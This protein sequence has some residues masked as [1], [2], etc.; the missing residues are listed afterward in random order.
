MASRQ[1]LGS[2]RGRMYGYGGGP[3]ASAYGGPANY[4]NPKMEQWRRQQSGEELVRADDRAKS[5]IARAQQSGVG[6]G[7]QEQIIRHTTPGG[8]GYNRQE[9]MARE[10][11]LASRPEAEQI[12]ML[13]RKANPKA[14]LPGGENF[15]SSIKPAVEPGAGQT[16]ESKWT[17]E[18]KKRWRQEQKDLANPFGPRMRK[19]EETG[20]WTAEQKQ[21]WQR[22][23][24]PRQQLAGITGGQAGLDRAWARMKANTGRERQAAATETPW[25]AEARQAKEAAEAKAMGEAR[26]AETQGSSWGMRRDPS[27]KGS[28]QNWGYNPRNIRGFGGAGRALGRASGFA[29]KRLGGAGGMMSQAIQR[30]QAQRKPAGPDRSG[31]VSANRRSRQRVAG[32]GGAPKRRTIGGTAFKGGGGTAPKRRTGGIG[33]GGSVRSRGLR[34]RGVSAF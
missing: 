3:L 29:G 17:P 28:L 27:S 1:N 5:R 11:Q 33:G 4:V 7:T 30:M 25:D 13:G 14:G 22:G 34:G 8:T 18:A 32:L 24:T 12:A 23:E 9:A 2:R 10:R 21:A 6:R 26:A 31:V 16:V 15:D 19:D 20:K